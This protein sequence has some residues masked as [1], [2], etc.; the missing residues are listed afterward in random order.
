MLSGIFA[1]FRQLRFTATAFLICSS[2][3]AE[4]SVNPITSRS[5]LW[6]EWNSTPN[7]QWAPSSV[8]YKARP[9]KSVSILKLQPVFPFRLNEDWTILTRTI[10]RFV[11]APSA[12]PKFGLTPL[13][14]PVLLGWHQRNKIGLSDVSPTVFLV[15]NLGS[16]WT[17]GVGPSVV[18]PV[19]DGPTSTGKL[20]L[21]PAF[22]GYYHRGPWTVGARLRNIW[23]LAGDPQRD[24]IHR[25]IVQPLIRYQFSK[26]WFLTSSPIISSDWTNRDG[27]GWTVPLGGGLGYGFILAKQ[28][29]QISLEAYFNAVKPLVGGEELLGDWTIRTQVQVLFPK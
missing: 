13:N 5:R 22:L 7:I 8:D 23:S 6:L 29:M 11:S 26:N 25:L 3:F 18:I 17:I 21:G 4:Q 1:F 12:T 2:A 28:P 16:D 14:E 27:S 24:D 9:D 20:S 15:P 19:S 10:L